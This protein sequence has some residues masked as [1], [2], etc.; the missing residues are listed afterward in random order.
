MEPLQP[1]L[2]ICI[3]TFQR[4]ENVVTIV[5][6]LLLC[7]RNDFEI[8]V[9]DNQSNDNTFSRLNSLIDSRLHV[10]QN[11][12]NVG[13]WLNVVRSISYGFGCVKMFMTDKDICHYQMLGAFI[14]FLKNSPQVGCGYCAFSDETKQATRIFEPGFESVR[15]VGYSWRHPTGY[16]FRDELLNKSDYL[17]AYRNSQLIGQFP[18]DLLL[19]ESAN[20]ACAAIYSCALFTREDSATA[21]KVQS[22]ITNGNSSDAFFKPENRLKVAINFA[23]HLDGLKLP[24][25]ASQRIE[26]NIFLHGLT[27]STNSFRI[28]LAN[29]ELC[30]HYGINS[31][32]ISVKELLAIA[33]SYIKNYFSLRDFSITSKCIRFISVAVFSVPELIRKVRHKL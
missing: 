32:V 24:Y 13:G 2:S 30:S 33:F 7:E 27:S 17:E 25:W 22:H 5:S 19:A 21:A 4:A 6:N 18:F 10:L 1:V 15:A 11:A 14:D 31:R 3:P 29:K 9:I 8:V 28:L 20:R 23:K 12:T 26:A 16:F